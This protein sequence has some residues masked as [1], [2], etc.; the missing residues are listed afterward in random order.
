[1]VQMVKELL[2]FSVFSFSFSTFWSILIK[3]KQL[4]YISFN[5]DVGKVLVC[6]CFADM[7]AKCWF[8]NVL[9]TLPTFRIIMISYCN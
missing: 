1:M 3:I 7:W 5:Y 9:P 6:Q 2:K 8:A 4:N